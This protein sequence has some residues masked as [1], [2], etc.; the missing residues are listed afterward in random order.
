MNQD[1]E[2][3]DGLKNHQNTRLASS[4][5]LTKKLE[6]SRSNGERDDTDDDTATP[7]P[8]SVGGS[9]SMTSSHTGRMEYI[10]APRLNQLI[11][12][13]DPTG[14]QSAHTAAEEEDGQGELNPAISKSASASMKPALNLAVSSK[15]KKREQQQQQQHRKK[16]QRWTSK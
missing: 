1:G 11:A 14:K 10:A 15:K 3:G 9:A 13:S 6:S 5:K 8:I 2:T 16:K 12:R 4:K 7:T